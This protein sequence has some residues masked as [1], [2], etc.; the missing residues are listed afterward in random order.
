M[1]AGLE[2]STVT[3]LRTTPEARKATTGMNELV[4]NGRLEYQA[5]DDKICYNPASL[6]LSWKVDLIP[7]VRVMQG[8]GGDLTAKSQAG[9]GS[10]FFLWLRVAEPG[11]QPPTENAR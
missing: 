6:P 4:I 9:Q 7:N 5:C 8:M 2:P 3:L 11:L 10:K 1:A